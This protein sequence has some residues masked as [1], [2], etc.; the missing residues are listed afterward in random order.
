MRTLVLQE[1]PDKLKE[2]LSMKEEAFVTEFTKLKN[3][4]LE[5]K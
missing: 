5:S 4:F 1:D 2:I 3:E